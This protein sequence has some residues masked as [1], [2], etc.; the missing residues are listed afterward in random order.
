MAPDMEVFLLSDKSFPRHIP[1]R[2][3][4]SCFW[5]QC[6]RW[7]GM[8]CAASPD[9]LHT[10]AFQSFR[11][12]FNFGAVSSV[13]VSSNWGLFYLRKTLVI[14]LQWGVHSISQLAVFEIPPDDLF[15]LTILK[16]LVRKAWILLTDWAIFREW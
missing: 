11:V 10:A 3:C 14:I 1:V 6:V 7:F 9:F 4:F 2:I 15:L 5:W 13:I 8:A 12:N 16:C